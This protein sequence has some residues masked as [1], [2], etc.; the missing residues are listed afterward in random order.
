MWTPVE[1]STSIGW[2]SAG[3]I[4]ELSEVKLPSSPHAEGSKRWGK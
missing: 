2:G 4:M 3:G 1:H